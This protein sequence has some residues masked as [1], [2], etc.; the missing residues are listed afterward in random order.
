MKTNHNAVPGDDDN[1]LPDAASAAAAAAADTPEAKAAEEQKAAQAAVEAGDPFAQGVAAEGGKV[2]GVAPPVAKT[3]AELD[4]EAAAAAG[5]G[6]D[7]GEE[8]G[9]TDP[10]KLAEKAEADAKAAT[11]KEISDLGITNPKT[12]ER[13]HE[14]SAEIRRLKPLET[15]LAT[16]KEETQRVIETAQSAVQFHDLVEKTG[17]SGEQ[18]GT[19]LG[20]LYA[21]NSRDPVLMRDGFEKLKVELNWLGKELGMAVDGYDPLDDPLN[22]DLKEAV[23][24][25]E[26]DRGPAVELASRRILD[27]KAKAH[28]DQQQTVTQTQTQAAAARTA[29]V[30]GARNLAVALATRDGEAF[31][32]KMAIITPAIHQIRE[33]APPTEWVDRIRKLYEE[34]PLPKTKK[35]AP[36]QHMPLRP[37]GSAGAGN[38]A[39]VISKDTPDPFMA[40][41]TQAK[42]A[43]K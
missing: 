29:A 37:T 35:K 38:T 6:E 12:K 41:V 20:Y 17:A 11:D 23:R 27:A 19:V 15:E 32:K 5:E 13:F 4:A 36:L 26:T 7:E 1:Q 14:M 16:A 18:V 24:K 10:A 28:N 40:G 8:E 2:E 3:Q 9:E 30:E 39:K 22:A 42:Q 21:I 43:G 34:T 33:T 31:Q 25:G